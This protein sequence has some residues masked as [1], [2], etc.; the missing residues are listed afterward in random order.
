MGTRSIV[1][2]L[3]ELVSKN[4]HSPE[5]QA[6]SMAAMVI[7]TSDSNKRKPIQGKLHALR[8]WAPVPT[9]NALMLLSCDAALSNSVREYAIKSLKNADS[10]AVRNS[11]AIEDYCAK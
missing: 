2:E 9:A 5:V 11:F 10:T 6:L 3:V 7:C 8:H 4:I 1:N